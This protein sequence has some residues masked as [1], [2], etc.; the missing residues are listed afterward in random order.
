MI[1][2]IVKKAKGILSPRNKGFAKAVARESIAEGRKIGRL[3]SREIK[4]EAPK[5][6]KVLKREAKIFAG[7]IRK[8][9][10]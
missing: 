9:R 4:K 7:K 8:I 3:A 10:R 5:A 2:R 1:K 6:K